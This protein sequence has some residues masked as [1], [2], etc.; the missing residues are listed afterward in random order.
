MVGGFKC[1]NYMK[2]GPFKLNKCLIFKME[3]AVFMMMS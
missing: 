3:E 1:V 2:L